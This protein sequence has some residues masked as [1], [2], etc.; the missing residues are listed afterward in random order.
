MCIRDRIRELNEKE[1]TERCVTEKT[2]MTRKKT[3]V[4]VM[5]VLA[6][7][8]VFAIL[9]FTVILPSIRYGRAKALYEAGR[10]EEA[11]A[12]FEAMNGYG[13]SAKMIL[14]CQYGMAEKLAASG[15]YDEAI[16]AFT[17]LDGYRDSAEKI[18]AC[19][20]AFREQRY[21]EAETLCQN[22]RYDLAYPIWTSLEGYRDSDERADGIFENYKAA[23]LKNAEVGEYVL[24]GA[25][26]QDNNASNGPEDVEWL[27]LSKDDNGILVVSRYALDYMHYTT[28]EDAVSWEEC[29]LHKWLNETFLNSAFGADEQL[30]IRDVADVGK[31]FL[32]STADAHRYF[33]SDEARRCAPTAYAIAHG[34][35]TS[36][37]YQVDGKDTCGWWLRNV[38]SSN[39]NAAVITIEGAV[40]TLD[41][42]LWLIVYGVRP[43]IW[44]NTGEA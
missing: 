37:T 38:Y 41:A 14:E 39:W 25:F 2:A 10:Y 33:D 9:L 24:F 22:G 3:A 31:V 27:V 30:K 23:R 28:S 18:E 4:I 13:D 15:K 29:S 40:S 16:A 43:A 44:I 36:S 19:E 6:F 20:A 26:E 42:Y 1:E 7:C 32:L 17:A 5:S 34:A 11:I 21:A 12:A 8:V 35:I